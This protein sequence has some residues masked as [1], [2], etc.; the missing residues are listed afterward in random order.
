MVIDG[1][2]FS[3]LTDIILLNYLYEIQEGML[4]ISSESKML[5]CMPLKYFLKLFYKVIWFWG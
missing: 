1:K 5:E 4:L 3:V 2:N